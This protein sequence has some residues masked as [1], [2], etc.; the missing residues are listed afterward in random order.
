[1]PAPK[2]SYNA[3]EAVP[4]SV[5]TGQ[6]LIGLAILEPYSNTPGAFF[7]IENFIA[8][9]Q[10]QPLMRVVAGGQVMG[11]NELDFSFDNPVMDDARYYLLM[12]N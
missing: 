7:A 10:T 11:G 5:S 12:P 6:H 4:D 2:Y 1:M 3:S 9:S 8:A